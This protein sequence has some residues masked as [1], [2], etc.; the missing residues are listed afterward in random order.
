MGPAAFSLQPDRRHPSGSGRH[1]GPTGGDTGHLQ[2]TRPILANPKYI[3]I[4]T[5]TQIDWIRY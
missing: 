5:H 3:H 4:Y 2:I 1:L